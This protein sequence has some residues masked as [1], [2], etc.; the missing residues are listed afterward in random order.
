MASEDLGMII[1][2]QTIEAHRRQRE[3][4]EELNLTPDQLKIARALDRD[5]II[6]LKEFAVNARFDH[7]I[8]P[9][10]RW[11]STRKEMLKIIIYPTFDEEKAD[12][13]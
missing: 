2:E 12:G 8:D 7:L 10:G 13:R 11:E 4:M 3:A 9:S 5:F 1:A 6:R